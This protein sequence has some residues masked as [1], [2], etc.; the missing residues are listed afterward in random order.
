MTKNS[1]ST[2]KNYFRQKFRF[3]SNIYILSQHFQHKIWTTSSLYKDSLPII[4]KDVHPAPDH[5]AC[6]ALQE[7]SYS[8]SIPKTPT[9]KSGDQ[10]T[11]P[12]TNMGVIAIAVNGVPVFNPYDRE[13]CDAGL[14]EFTNLDL[15]YAHPAS[16][17]NYHYH[18]FS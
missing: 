1:F 7:Q 12:A 18:V 2:K 15:C 6:H 16:R 8:Y 4:S 13:C 17:G 3:F 9:K 5:N 11:F 14:F 10:A